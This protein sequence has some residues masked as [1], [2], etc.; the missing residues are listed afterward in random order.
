MSKSNVFYLV[1]ASL[2]VLFSIIG[3]AKFSPYIISY[4]LN[5]QSI[6]LEKAGAWGDSFAVLNTLFSGAAFIGLLITVIHQKKSNNDQAS[7]FKTQIESQTKQINEQS[8]QF[9]SQN[10]SLLKNKFDVTFFEFLKFKTELRSALEYNPYDQSTAIRNHKYLGTYSFDRAVEDVTFYIEELIDNN[11]EY[12]VDELNILMKEIFYKKND[13]IFSI[14]FRTLYRYF[15]LIYDAEYLTNQEKVDYG[16]IIRAQLSGTEVLIIGMNGLN[17][18]SGDL[19][20]YITEYRLL[21]YANEGLIKTVL[22][23]HYPPETFEARND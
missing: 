11:L 21:K 15:K 14:Y 10:L 18:N 3:W 19:H 16:N 2:L 7:Q 22:I 9:E 23:K 12:S 13:I 20:K 17:S 6:T 1:L 8:K 4:A 5:E